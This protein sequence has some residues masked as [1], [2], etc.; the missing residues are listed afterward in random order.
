[1]S[2]GATISAPARACESADFASHCS[3]VSLST[4]PS[5]MYPQ[6]PWLVYSQLQTSVTT[7]SREVSLR[8]ARMARCTMPLSSYAPVAISSFVSGRPNR[9]TPP[10][11]SAS[12]SI[13]SLTSSSID[14]W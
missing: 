14:I 9:I 6:W 4:S 10:I 7:S 8:M 1:M 11:P 2:E 5:L 3:V 13:H 12:T